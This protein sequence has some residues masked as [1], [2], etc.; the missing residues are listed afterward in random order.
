[1][2]WVSRWSWFSP[3]LFY[4]QKIKNQNQKQKL[5]ERIDRS[6]RRGTCFSWPFLLVH[7]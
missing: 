2:F 3:P 1:L 6:S 7:L 4:I 5:L